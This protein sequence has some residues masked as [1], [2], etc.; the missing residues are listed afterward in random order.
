MEEAGDVM[1]VDGLGADNSG[2]DGGCKDADTISPQILKKPGN[3]GKTDPSHPVLLCI[4][5][6]SH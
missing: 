4:G 6:K 3:G 2:Q 1:D 5:G